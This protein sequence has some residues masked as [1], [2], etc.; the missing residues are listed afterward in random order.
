MESADDAVF[1]ADSNTDIQRYMFTNGASSWYGFQSGSGVNGA[2]ASDLLI[3]MD[4]PGFI[5]GTSN[6][7][8]AIS[9]SVPQTSGGS[10]GEGNSIEAYKFVTTEVSGGTTTGNV[11]Y[12]IWVPHS[13]LNNSSQ[14]YSQIEVNFAGS[15]TSLSSLNTDSSLRSIDVVYNGSNW[16]NGT[17]RVFSNNGGFNQG[18]SGVVDTTSNYFRGGTLI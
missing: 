5:N 15:P 18:S 10:D 4:W 7:P 17:Y 16:P 9:A 1:G 3:Y 13:L 11:W 14:V 2:N 8:A 6:V 12:S